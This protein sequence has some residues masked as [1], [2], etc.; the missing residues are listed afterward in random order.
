[1][2]ETLKENIQEYSLEKYDGVLHLVKGKND[3]ALEEIDDN[4]RLVTTNFSNEIGEFNENS[5]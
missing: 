2:E 4:A 1:M 5:Y 3:I